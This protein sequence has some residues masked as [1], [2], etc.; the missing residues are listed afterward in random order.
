MCP[1][2]SYLFLIILL[3]YFYIPP[4]SDRIGKHLYDVGY[5]DPAEG[6][7]PCIVDLDGHLDDYCF[8]LSGK[9]KDL[10]VE[11]IALDLELR[12]YSLDKICLIELDACLCILE[13][14]TEEDLEENEISEREELSR[15][16]SI[17]P[18]TS[19]SA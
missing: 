7:G 15:S 1:F 11:S 14:K 17:N 10:D 4:D 2:L 8:L 16:A 19:P 9:C 18:M 6:F 13:L 12:D 3:Y 5:P